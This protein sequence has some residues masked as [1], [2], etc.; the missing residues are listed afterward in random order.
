[1]SWY[2]CSWR[3]CLD[4][5]RSLRILPQ[6]IIVHVTINSYVYFISNVQYM[7]TRWRKQIRLWSWCNVLIN[8][9]NV[10]IRIERKK[11]SVKHDYCS[12]Y[13]TIIK[14]QNI[15]YSGVTQE[16][17]RVIK[18]QNKRYSG[19]TQEHRRVCCEPNNMF[20]SW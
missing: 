15:R 20:I 9:S 10:R 11:Y 3:K 13:C 5:M 4:V 14:F 18:F 12:N 8:Y 7:Q 19:V 16:H 1:M 6:H 17:R 2:I